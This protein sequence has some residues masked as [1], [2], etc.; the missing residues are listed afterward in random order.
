[1]TAA[2][3]APG[4]AFPLDAAKLA[5]P[6]L[7]DGLVDRTRL[8]RRLCAATDVRVVR[9]GAPAGYGKTT[10][11]AQWEAADERAFAWLSLDRRDNDPLVFLTYLAAAVTW[12]RRSTATSSRRSPACRRTRSG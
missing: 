5:A 7:R 8:V 2:R 6:R 4:A 9:I 11:L 10:L 1:M 3:E 12:W